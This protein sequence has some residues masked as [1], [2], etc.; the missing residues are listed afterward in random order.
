MTNKTTLYVSDVGVADRFREKRD[1]RAMSNAEFIKMLLEN[2]TINQ[3]R[4]ELIEQ[5][6]IL[7]ERLEN[8]I[9]GDQV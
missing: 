1:E 3:S 7:N 2:H 4:D 8:A 5:T 9:E 6:E